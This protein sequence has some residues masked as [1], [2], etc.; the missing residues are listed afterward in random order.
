MCDNQRI[1][2]YLVV[3]NRLAAKVQWG[4]TTLQCQFCN[5]LLPQ[6]MDEISRFAKPNNLQDLRTLS[7]TIGAQYWEQ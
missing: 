6:I 2:K 1:T 3:F 7:Q 5:R 4:N